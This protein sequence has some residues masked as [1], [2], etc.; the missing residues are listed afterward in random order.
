MTYKINDKVTFD[1]GFGE[2]HTGII[3]DIDY[4]D[5][6]IYVE[7][8]PECEYCVSVDDILELVERENE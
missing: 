3:T 2:V 5:V 7:D 1:D 4:T 8:D 6:N